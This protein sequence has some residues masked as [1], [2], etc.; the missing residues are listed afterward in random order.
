M[1]IICGL[2]Y[3]MTLYAHLHPKMPCRNLVSMIGLFIMSISSLLLT[4]D[5]HDADLGIVIGTILVLFGIIHRYTIKA[6][7]KDLT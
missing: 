5:H 2:L 6:I 3:I 7:K 1:T 4:V